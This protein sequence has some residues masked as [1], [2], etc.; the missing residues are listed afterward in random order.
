MASVPLARLY[1]RLSQ[2]FAADDFAAGFALGRHILRHYPRFIAAY[3]QMGLAA[4]SVG[5]LADSVDLL[6]RALSAHPEAPDAWQALFL[7]AT[8]LELLPEAAIAEDYARDLIPNAS[9]ETP[10]A[11][12][13][14]A[15]RAGDWRTA[16]AFYREGLT[17]QP[18]RMDAALGLAES[19]YRLGHFDG[20]QTIA[21]YVLSELPYSLKAHLLLALIHAQ[22]GQPLPRAHLRAIRALDP[23][24]EL[25]QAWFPDINLTGLFADSPTLADWDE[26][27]R[28]AYAR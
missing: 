28:W 15:R 1:P 2:L 14:A 24:A 16:Y 18:H 6:Q 27:E 10:I 11:R 17:P 9:P 4:Q 19:L 13:H 22:T 26:E 3:I 8:H 12:G 7:A 25:S 20:A 5:L 21:R 23:L